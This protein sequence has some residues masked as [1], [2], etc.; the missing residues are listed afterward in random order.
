VLDPFSPYLEAILPRR[1]SKLGQA[2][3]KKLAYKYQ[4][5]QLESRKDLPE[6]YRE[7]VV[8][9]DDELLRINTG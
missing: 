9:G 2:I 1:D 5:D 7:V 4:V 6:W 3:L 8:H